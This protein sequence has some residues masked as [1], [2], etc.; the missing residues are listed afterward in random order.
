[1]QADR[2]VLKVTPQL[3]ELEKNCLAVVWYAHFFVRY[4]YG[5]RICLYEYLQYV[6]KKQITTQVA[7]L[8]VLQLRS[9][10]RLCSSYVNAYQLD[11]FSVQ[12]QYTS[13]SVF[14][15]ANKQMSSRRK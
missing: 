10:I 11:N 3:R 6:R 7:L 2:W 9:F 5:T 4:R 13:I 12:H 14:S 15:Q 1:M 8:P